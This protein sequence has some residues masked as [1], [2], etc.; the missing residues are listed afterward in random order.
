M[1]GHIYFVLKSVFK[2][3]DL[4]YDMVS[5]MVLV[6]AVKCLKLIDTMPNLRIKVDLTHG[7]KY[8]HSI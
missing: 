5:R 8:V 1:S 7:N 3:I 2:R 4:I 6:S